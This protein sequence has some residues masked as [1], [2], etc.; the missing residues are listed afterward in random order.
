L[1]IVPEGL[2]RIIFEAYHAN[3]TSGHLGEYKTLHRIRLRF[4]FPDAAERR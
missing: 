4:L 1:V 2:Q 3:P